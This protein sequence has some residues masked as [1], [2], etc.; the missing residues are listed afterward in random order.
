MSEDLEAVAD[1]TALARPR[2]AGFFFANSARYGNLLADV[3]GCSTTVVHWAMRDH[4]EA[5][6]PASEWLHTLA[7]SAQKTF[8]AGLKI[9]LELNAQDSGA[10]IDKTLKAIAPFWSKV[11]TVSLADEPN[12]SPETTRAVAVAT[13]SAMKKAG[14]AVKPLGCLYHVGQF[15][16]IR[17]VCDPLDWVGPEFY[18]TTPTGFLESAANVKDMRTNIARGLAAIPSTKAVVPIVMAYARNLEFNNIGDHAKGS[19]PYKKAVQNLIDLVPEMYDGCKDARVTTVL[20]FS[21]GRASGCAEFPLF[22]QA[23]KKLCRGVT[24]K[25]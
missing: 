22:A 2:D 15:A 5:G 23:I 3:K 12:W 21:Y 1:L 4:P 18:S 24:G 19:A 17:K 10:K 25:K 6:A 7:Q 16:K 14:L 9:H 13:R 8:D 11:E 20:C